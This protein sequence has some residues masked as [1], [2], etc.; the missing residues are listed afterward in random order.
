MNKIKKIISEVFS[1]GYGNNDYLSDLGN[2]DMKD[3][4]GATAFQPDT[5]GTQ[6]GLVNERRNKNLKKIKYCRD[7]ISELLKEINIYEEL[8]FG[9]ADLY[10]TQDSISDNPKTTSRNDI[11]DVS[12]GL[13]YKRASDATKDKYVIDERNKS[14]MDGSVGVSVKKQCRLG[15]LG[16]TSKACNQGEIEN[17]NF[18]KINEEPL[19]KNILKLNELPFKDDIMALGGEIYSVGGSVRD[20]ILGKES[21][22]LD[23][24]ITNLPLNIIEKVLLDY[25]KVDSVGKSFGVLKFKPTGSKE[26]IDVTIPRKETATG[27][28]GHRD[29]DV[30]SDHTLSIEDDLIR[31]DLTINAIAKDIYG[32]YI[33]PYGGIEDIKSGKIREVNPNAFIEDP[34]R[35][36]R[37]IQFA[38]RFNFNI[39]P[40]TMSLIQ[41]HAHTIKK[42]PKDRILKEFNKIVTKGDV[43][44]GVYE[45]I[46]T[47]LYNEIFHNTP[48]INILNKN[49][50][51]VK[52]MG[53]FIYLL[54]EHIDS[55]SSFY[56]NNLHGEVKTFKYI[57]AL[58]KSK[59][60]TSDR[61]KNRII[62][63][64]MYKI[65]PESFKSGV[66]SKKIKDTINKLLAG[67]YPK[68][69]KDLEISGR[70]LMHMGYKEDA[71][72]GDKL[73]EIL[74]LIYS[75]RLNNNKNDI[76]KYLQQ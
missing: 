33:D 47:N 53:D 31:R 5:V 11:Y 68:S 75:D 37:A 48:P 44:K 13:E 43:K 73:K 52:N 16:S 8:T 21:K 54:L 2:P 18:H 67:K 29:F 22:D 55:P 6:M 28:G 76:M 25:G 56:K 14:Y 36:L 39:D 62:A 66:L 58:E 7:R 1:F 74:L 26:E 40:K 27:G 51:G 4:L 3:K 59:E 10:S 50:D 64:R 69:L 35:M 12:D 65:S 42:E 34:L 24:L 41:K 45:L 57:K 63:N 20:E 70:D 23:I 60:A 72:L 30:Q 38:S 32:N 15:G 71:D 9:S 17:L 49:W 61:V 19:N 46:K